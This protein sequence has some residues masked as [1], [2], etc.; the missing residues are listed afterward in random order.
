MFI[1]P[2]VVM[3]VFFYLRFVFPHLL[4]RYCCYGVLDDWGVH[5]VRRQ[6]VVAV[7]SL[8]LYW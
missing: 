8:H 2:R 3:A 7:S 5:S 6:L 1:T 4:D